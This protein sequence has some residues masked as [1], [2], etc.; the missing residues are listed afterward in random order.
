MNDTGT[1]AVPGLYRPVAALSAVAAN[2]LAPGWMVGASN[3]V[4]SITMGSAVMCVPNAERPP[5]VGAT[6]IFPYMTSI[7]T[8][9][10]ASTEGNCSAGSTARTL[11]AKLTTTSAQA[12]WFAGSSVQ[13]LATAIGSRTCPRSITLSNNINPV[14]GW[15]SNVPPFGLIQIDGEQFTYFGRSNAGNKLPANTL[16][17]IQCA[18]NGTARAAHAVNATVFPLNRF[19]PSYPWPVIPSINAND[20]TPS[21]SA[22]YYPGW[23]VDNNVFAF[24]VA[25]GA[26][27][28]GSG[29]W[30]ANAKIETCLSSRGR[31]RSTESRGKRSTIPG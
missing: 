24:P 21:G 27:P 15:E 31:T 6:V 2:P 9:T 28:I 23:N 7:F 5:A 25:N 10:V 14:A 1:R 17:G 20:T 11:N 16:Y 8:S 30:S 22:T 18:Q 26:H 13:N 4:A 19:K 12:E 29:G 3:G